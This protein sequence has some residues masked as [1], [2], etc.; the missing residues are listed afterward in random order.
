MNSIANAKQHLRDTYLKY[1][2][3]NTN[4]YKPHTWKLLGSGSAGD[5]I[6]VYCDSVKDNILVKIYHPSQITDILNGRGYNNMIWAE[7]STMRL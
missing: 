2:I 3:C 4:E 5:G 1:T 6:I 7:L